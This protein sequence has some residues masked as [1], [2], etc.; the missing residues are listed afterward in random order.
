MRYLLDTCAFVWIA[1]K[2]EKLP[3]TTLSLV[4]DPD[5]EILI[6]SVSAAEIACAYE[7][8]RLVLDR[9][10]K[11]WFRFVAS[12]NGWEVLDITLRIIEEAW[13]LPGEFHADLAD[14]VIVATARSMD[15]VV[16]TGDERI[17]EYPHVESLF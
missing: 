6:S 14:R 2:P 16:I 4:S 1:A 8:R 9:H 7:R 15:L 17:L 12:E 11:T 10:W 5:A 13:S 3:D